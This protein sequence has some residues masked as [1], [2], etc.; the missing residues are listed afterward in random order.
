MGRVDGQQRWD[1]MLQN[2][3]FEDA[4]AAFSGQ[5]LA[6]RLMSRWEYG[7]DVADLSGAGGPGDP[8]VVMQDELGRDYTLG[9]NGTRN[10]IAVYDG[11]TYIGGVAPI[12]GVGKLFSAAKLWSNVSKGAAFVRTTKLSDWVRTGK[13]VVSNQIVK[14]AGSPGATVTWSI[15]GGGPNMG[16]HYH[17]HRF[18]WYKP[19]IWFKNTPIIKP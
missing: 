6:H 17:I 5:Q 1:N 15:K 10:Y 13:T 19:H 11:P 3:R 16:F 4:R 18:N 12:P 2:S 8:P 7:Y 14:G 9:A